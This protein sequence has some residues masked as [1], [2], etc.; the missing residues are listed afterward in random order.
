MCA[1]DVFFPP[2]V[3]LPLSTPNHQQLVLIN[4]SGYK[5]TLNT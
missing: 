5:A 2:S 1:G 4:R 3:F